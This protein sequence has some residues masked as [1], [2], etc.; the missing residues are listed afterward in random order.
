MPGR[1]TAVRSGNELVQAVAA[2]ASDLLL[3]PSFQV[4]VGRRIWGAVRRIDVIVRDPLTRHALGIE[5][6]YQGGG[7]SAEEKIPAT[8]QDIAA[9]PIPGIVV[10]SGE[11]F[12]ANMR[13][14]LYSTGK[15]VDLEDLEM[16][17]RLFFGF[18]FQ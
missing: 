4:K 10:I 16:W 2:I 13:S 11:G 12:T 6:K 9:W 8:V 7:G 15:A 1:D 18:E 14:Y 5:C 17:L 3:D